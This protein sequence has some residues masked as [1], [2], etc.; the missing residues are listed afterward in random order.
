MVETGTLSQSA[1][2]SVDR[3]CSGCSTAGL[4]PARGSL[5]QTLTAQLGSVKPLGWWYCFTMKQDDWPA[6]LTHGIGRRVAAAR[7][8][9]HLSAAALAQRCA[10]LGVPTLTRQVIA[11]IENGRR[12]SVS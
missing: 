10:G 12:E 11:F 6:R 1:T 3:Y 4:P 9:Q 7:Q 2:C 5:C 8:E